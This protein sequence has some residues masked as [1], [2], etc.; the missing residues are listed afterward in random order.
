[1]TEFLPND[2]AASDEEQFLVLALRYLDGVADA[3]E[4]AAL[5]RRIHS[6]PQCRGWFVALCDQLGMLHEVFSA[7]ADEEMEGGLGVVRGLGTSVQ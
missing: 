5:A 4:E 2:A 1:M 3:E 6:D 7:P